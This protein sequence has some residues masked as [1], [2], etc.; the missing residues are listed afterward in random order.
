MEGWELEQMRRS[1]EVA[2]RAGAHG[3][4]LGVLRDDA[5]IDAERMWEFVG[6]ARAMR[7]AFHRAFDQTPDPDAALD[8]LVQLGVD[9]VLTSGHASTAIDG[10]NT[11]ARHVGRA[12]DRIVILAGGK[13][14]APNVARLVELTGVREVH[15]WALD[16]AS[17]DF[18]ELVATAKPRPR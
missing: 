5:T 16:P 10:A 6:R 7:V 8:T 12:G 13:V 2:K 15:A 11:L 9:L 3:V 1:I 4:V 14:R 17:N 18:A